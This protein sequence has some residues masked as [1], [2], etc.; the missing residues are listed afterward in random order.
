MELKLVLKGPIL[1]VI[2]MT[3][4]GNANILLFHL[5]HGT[6]DGVSN[7]QIGLVISFQLGRGPRLSGLDQSKVHLISVH[8][9]SS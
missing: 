4:D 5:V 2:E 9:S 7:L 8:I 3:G 1:N 6:G